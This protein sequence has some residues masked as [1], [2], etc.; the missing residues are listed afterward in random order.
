M[1]FKQ[2]VAQIDGQINL[3]M[4]RDIKYILFIFHVNCHK[5]IANF[6]CVFSIIN[7]TKLLRFYV[8][9]QNGIVFQSNA[10]T[11][12]FLAP[13]IFVKAFSEENNVGQNCFIIIRINSV[14]HSVKIEG[15]DFIHKHL[16]S[17]F[18]CEIIVI[19]IPFRWICIWWQR[20]LMRRLI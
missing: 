2:P 3:I 16:I 14:A 1:A 10:F 18:I 17:I 8:N 7:K 5:F 15:E 4:L 12:D 6:W 20:R 13:A 19:S 11:F 9:F